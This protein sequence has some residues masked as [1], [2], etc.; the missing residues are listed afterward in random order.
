MSLRRLLEREIK[1]GHLTVVGPDNTTYHIRHSGPSVTWLFNDTQTMNRMARNWETE[2]A[3]SYVQEGWD[4]MDG[5]LYDLLDIL[6][7][8]LRPSSSSILSKAAMKLLANLKNRS[9]T[10]CNDP[11]KTSFDNLDV[12]V[13]RN[14]LD[15]ELFYSCAYFADTNMTLEQ[16][17]LAQLE[18]LSKKIFLQP[19]HTV[20]DISCGW[21]GSALFLAEKYGVH[22]TGITRSEHQFSA[23]VEHAKL[24]GLSHL[25]R[26]KLQDVSDET[27]VF[28]RII[29]TG[30]FQRNDQAHFNT[31]FDKIEKLLN[32]GGIALVHLIGRTGSP[33]D[34][35]PWLN[36]N[37][38]PFGYVPAL[39]EVTRSVENANLITTDINILHQHCAMTLAEWRKRL[40]QNRQRL[41]SQ[42]GN[43][44]SRTWEFY[45]TISEVIF[46]HADI[47]VYEIQASKHSDVMSIHKNYLQPADAGSQIIQFPTTLISS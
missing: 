13:L 16:A 44:I 17:Q 12:S 45:L 33:D 38:H 23:A 24:R 25:V 27:Q 21:G 42:D 10:R 18:H 30:I 22:V 8:N 35:N 5:S 26:F 7:T 41:I 31:Y 1:Y 37:L 40:H 28:D 43:T 47:T 3:A 20:L 9:T 39:S 46:R 4:V 11:R 6:R 32:P 15:A 14:F 29:S 19:S 2:L 34:T 36:K